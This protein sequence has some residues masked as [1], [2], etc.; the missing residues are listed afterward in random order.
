[1]KKLLGPACLFIVVILA[2]GALA[3]A[4]PP[5]PNLARLVAHR[6]S[7]TQAERNQYTYRES[8][9]I[10]ELNDRGGIRGDYSELRDVIFS[11][12]MQ[13]EDVASGPPRNSLKNLVLTPED[14]Q[15]I[16]N[17]QPF[18]LVEDF[19]PVYETK[20]RGEERV[21]EQDCWVLQVRPRQILAGQRLFDGMLWVK[22][23]DYSV[24]RSEGQA[25]PQIRTTKSE[26]LFPRFTTIRRAVNGFWFPVYT[27]ADDTLQFRT[28]PQRIKLMIKYNDY[29]KFGTNT[30]VTF[31]GGP[32]GKPDVKK[33]PPK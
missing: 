9:L 7:Q 3:A 8:V 15:D 30:T 20:F 11:P 32:D 27:L 6:E 19:M 13:R 1:M 33:E 29:K 28:G 5:P 26:N 25:V 16:R 14:F 21:D 10:Q 18:V 12:V 4:E 22:K 23:D 24:V 17:I 2:N 31:E